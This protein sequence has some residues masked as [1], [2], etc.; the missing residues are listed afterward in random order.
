M[1]YFKANLLSLIKTLQKKV[2][3]CF[4]H[5]GGGGINGNSL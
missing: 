4:Y 5:A 3:T 2:T 1:E